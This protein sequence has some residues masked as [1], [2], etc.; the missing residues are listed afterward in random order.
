MSAKTRAKALKAINDHGVLLVYPVNNKK[1]PKSLWSVLYPRSEMVWEWDEDSDGR[2]A[3]LWHLRMQLSESSDVVY[4]KWYQG[5]ASF[6]SKE[7]FTALLRV[8]G[9]ADESPSNLSRDSRNIIDIL[10]SDSPIST[11]MIKQGAELQG[12]DLESQ[13][14]R[15]MKPL[16]NHLWIVGYGEI[17][18]SSFPSLAVGAT[19]VLFEDLWRASRELSMKE[20]QVTVDRFM[21]VGS[22]FR[23]FFNRVLAER[24]KAQKLVPSEF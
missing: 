22:A 16:W 6:F 12:K 19:Q 18:D 17:E 13:Y 9:T 3:D 10:L 2:V 8:F 11:K 5:R 4:A 24:E 23:K 20:A 14:N 15:A 21:P 7:L 1:E